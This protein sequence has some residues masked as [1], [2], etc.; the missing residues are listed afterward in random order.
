LRLSFRV[1]GIYR[2][3]AHS[4][5]ELIIILYT[6][7]VWK[8]HYNTGDSYQSKRKDGRYAPSPSN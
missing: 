8:L 6:V 1:K 4:N 3:W 7:G 5:N 2:K